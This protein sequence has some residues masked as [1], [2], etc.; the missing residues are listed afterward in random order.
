[1][2]EAVTAL[3]I[4][5]ITETQIAEMLGVPHLPATLVNLRT[6]RTDG[7]GHSIVAHWMQIFQMTQLNQTL[8]EAALYLQRG[9]RNV[10]IV[11]KSAL[12]VMI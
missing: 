7:Q 12:A 3:T 1:M 9:G 11:A 2:T 8:L 5:P 6:A 4:I 10:K